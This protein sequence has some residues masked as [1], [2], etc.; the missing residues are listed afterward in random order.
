MQYAVANLIFTIIDLYWWVVIAMA[1]MSWLVA[2]DVVN[3]RSR[4]VH[5]LW[6]ALNALT[7][8]VLRP[9]RSVLPSL[10]GMDISPII[11]LLVLQFLRNLVAGQLGGM[12]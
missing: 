4:V 2:L 5:S 8:P 3:T 10:G 1:V 7:E 9:I 6:N 11:L 12:G